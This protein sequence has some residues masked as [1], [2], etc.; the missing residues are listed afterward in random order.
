MLG[1]ETIA[2]KLFDMLEAEQFRRLGLDDRF[3]L[4][5]RIGE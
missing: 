1:F 3:F 5:C 2:T 4:M